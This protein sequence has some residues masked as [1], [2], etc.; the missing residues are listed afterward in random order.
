MTILYPIN[1]K[2][3]AGTITQ[4]KKK[5]SIRYK[6]QSR[7]FNIKDFHIKDY[8]SEEDALHATHEYKK[9]WAIINN[10]VK[11]KYEIIKDGSI[12]YI[13]LYI[14]PDIYTLIDKDDI[15]YIDKNIWSFN[16]GFI[17]TTDAE[18]NKKL[19]FHELK[20]GHTNILHMN[21]NKLDNR[22]FNIKLNEDNKETIEEH[23][24]AE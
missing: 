8:N 16:K 4:S 12:E 20:Y 24:I 9:K 21:G 5:F 19:S 6:T 2:K 3:Y 13:K 14:K 1:I 7:L 11:N 18:S 22:S 15:D 23:A 17:K 10:L